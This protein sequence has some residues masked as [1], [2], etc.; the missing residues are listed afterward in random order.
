MKELFHKTETSKMVDAIARSLGVRT[1][2]AGY[3]IQTT[4][5]RQL[6]TGGLVT[7][8]QS[9]VQLFQDLQT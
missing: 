8:L 7:I 9:M 4:K 6:N 1:S 2:G 5:P 3:S